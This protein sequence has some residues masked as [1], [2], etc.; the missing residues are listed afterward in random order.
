MQ[1]AVI[2]AGYVGLVSGICFASLGFKVNIV[3]KNEEKINLLNKGVIPIFEE[4]LE[5][6]LKQNRQ[7]LNFST[8]VE[9]VKNSDVIFIAVGTPQDSKTG[10]AN[11]SYLQEAGKQIAP[12]LK[13]NTTVVI[14]S[15]VPPKTNEHFKK[16][17]EKSVKTKVYFASN[18]EFLRE[19]S[20]VK[21]F[22]YPERIVIG[23]EDAF[24]KQ[25]LEFLYEKIIATGAK[26]IVTDITSAE[27]SKYASN[28]FLATKVAFINEISN[29]CFKLNANIDDISKIMGLDSRIGAKFLQAGPGFGGSCF[30]KDILALENISKQNKA[31]SNIT[32]A[33]IKANKKRIENILQHIQNIA[34]NIKNKNISVLGLA[35]KAGTDDIRS[36]PAIYIVE[37][38]LKKG[39]KINVHD[40]KAMQNAKNYFLK[41]KNISFFDNAEDAINKKTQLI[42]IL[43]EWKEYIQID[44]EKL[45]NENK[46]LK[47]FDTRNLLK[48]HLKHKRYFSL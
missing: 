38:L 25:K 7:N 23:V 36:S 14:K 48:K 19:G 28:T 39:A 2:G 41:Q 8:K 13:E 16:I 9:N 15:T 42:L 20:G 6:I 32:Q 34:G 43:T 11:L 46:S 31:K 1:I 12:F 22:L 3:D 33:V 30:P 47:V 17:I 45:L 10:K 21:D 40:F 5:D 37:K 4:S 18:P 24:S 27:L 29:L 44:F 35:F 26:F